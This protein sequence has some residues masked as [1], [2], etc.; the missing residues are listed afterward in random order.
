VI[1]DQS[2]SDKTR[3]VVLLSQGMSVGHYRIVEKIGAGGM[4]E[5]YLA[6]D[7]ELDR[8]V[9][10]KFLPSHLCQDV[11][12]RARFKREA[13]AVAK[14][15]HPNI[16]SVFEVGEF[17][18][19]PFFAMQ[20]VEGQTLKEAIGG[21]T[22]PLDRV[23]EIGI[24]VC[25]GLQAAHDKGITHRDI[26]P[27]NILIDSYGRA[28]IVDFGLASVL[29]SDPLT[30]TGSTLGTVGYMSPEQVR[31]EKVDHRTDL[32]SLGVVLYE[33]ITG[34]SPFKSE[35][36]AATLHAITDTKPELLARFRR[37]VPQEFQAVI[38]KALDKDIATRYQHADEL[39]ADL[40]R[41]REATS[42]SGRSQ[43][44]AMTARPKRRNLAIAAVAGTL[45]ILVTVVWL[46]RVV[47]DRAP[48]PVAKPR[49]ITFDGDVQ[50]V[51]ISPDGSKLAF[52]R[53]DD[54]KQRLYTYSL[55]GG[56]PLLVFEGWVNDLA[57]SPDGNSVLAVGD[58]E[59]DSSRGVFLVPFMGGSPRFFSVRVCDPC[60]LSWDPGGTAFY[61]HESCDNPHRFLRFDV[62]TG[63]S[64]AYPLSMPIRWVYAIKCSP[65]GDRLLLE[66]ESDSG[67]GIWTCR[68]DGSDSRRL[69]DTRRLD[70]S[71]T[72][73][74]P[75][76]KA[77]YFMRFIGESMDLMKQ[78]I[79]PRTGEVVGAPKV[80]VSGL[81]TRG[82]IS[83]TREGT[84]LAYVRVEESG[85]LALW[86][87]HEVKGKTEYAREV[88]GSSTVDSRNPRFSPDGSKVAF[89]TMR[90]NEGILRIFSVG[91]RTTRTLDVAG[92]NIAA[93]AW[94]PDG[95]TLAIMYDEKSVRRLCLAD[96][97]SG[98]LLQM[99]PSWA[100]L[101]CS[102]DISWA[103]LDNILIQSVGNRNFYKL[104]PK[105]DKVET[106]FLDDSIGWKF[107]PAP[108]AHNE[109]AIKWN[110]VDD[111]IYRVSLDGTQRA[112]MVK[113]VFFED[114]DEPLCW[115]DDDEHLYWSK[116]HGRY[117]LRTSRDG[118]V[119]DTVLD[120]G[121]DASCRVAMTRDASHV[122]TIKN[123]V[124]KD[125]WLIE[126]FD[127]DVK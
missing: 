124:K 20:H 96:A 39:K 35:S 23:Q 94:S 78:R 83:I 80:L 29:G 120:L 2:N 123:E 73:W 100:D 8:Q 4:G 117:I 70:K 13:Q 28:R 18:G 74:S 72:C 41:V 109:V 84:R 90:N 57:W 56:E 10:L 86:S 91:G 26:K 44:A 101:N 114:E 63:D 121:P 36:E 68:A 12:C 118:L 92:R 102:E 3:S 16:V 110:E 1:D 69:L 24:Q 85:M 108:S 104:D 30:K 25:D 79:D 43:S 45:V 103:P 55:A 112:R 81:A 127:P 122:F 111:G 64:I 19:R 89:V 126:D 59:K 93:C 6:E 5:V 115:S 116:Y 95:N 99:P 87:R 88:I 38:D 125:A 46:L 42:A 107:F 11:D 75:D 97:N 76:G 58:N 9:A 22:L 34:H 82:P 106:L 51:D 67:C 27:S 14:L 53:G 77:V 105:S 47:G 71:S 66:V 98:R 119:T 48:T 62:K 37:E 40:K 54:L 50:L 65:K 7:T 60:R 15:D 61:Y 49:Q 32:F 31:G 17:Q 21:K 33:L 113:F 52:V